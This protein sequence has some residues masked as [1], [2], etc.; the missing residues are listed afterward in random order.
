M[1]VIRTIR[2]CLAILALAASMCVSAAVSRLYAADQVN[3]TVLNDSGILDFD[4]E[5]KHKGNSGS[6]LLGRGMI[7]K[8]DMGKNEG[9]PKREKFRNKIII[10]E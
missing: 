10:H 8:Q 7:E 2:I 1:R 9:A 6:S 5:Q 3:A 4:Q